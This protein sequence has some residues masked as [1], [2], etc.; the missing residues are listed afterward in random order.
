[1]QQCNY[2]MR[3]GSWIQGDSVLTSLCNSEG[4]GVVRMRF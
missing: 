2:G 4:S 3:T 1:V